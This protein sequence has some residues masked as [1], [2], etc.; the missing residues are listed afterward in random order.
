MQKRLVA[1]LLA[2]IMVVSTLG[3]LTLLKSYAEF[4]SS[5]GEAVQQSE[6]PQEP[7]PA[8]QAPT[9]KDPAPEAPVV[10]SQ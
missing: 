1:V 6:A 2:F 10:N 3:P 9:V 5:P 7:A 4:E 8:P